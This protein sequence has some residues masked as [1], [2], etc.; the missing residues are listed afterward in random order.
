MQ[1]KLLL[2]HIILFIRTQLTDTIERP[3]RTET[4]P[5]SFYLV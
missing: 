1:Q 2:F 4:N 5:L 3:G